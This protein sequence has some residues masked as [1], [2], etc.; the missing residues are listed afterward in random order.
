MVA[1]T[2]KRASAVPLWV[3]LAIVPGVVAL[4]I[5]S[6]QLSQPYALFGL[7]GSDDGVWL[8]PAIRL[9][10]GA[11]PYRDYA[12]VHPPGIALLLAPIG[13]L[14]DT[15]DALA[16]ARVV[17]ALVIGLDA[18]LAAIA[19]RYRGPVAMLVGG[20][21][22]AVFP[23]TASIGHS[24][25]IDPYLVLCCLLGMLAMFRGG[26]LAPPRRLLLAGAFFGLAAAMKAWGIFPAI[27]ALLVCLP[28]WRSAVRPFASGLVLGF[29]LPSLPFFMAA[30]SA[31]VHDVVFSQIIRS[32][33]G[34]GFT[35]VGDRLQLLLGF[36]P[37]T[38]ATMTYLALVIAGVLA[39][40]I[41]ATYAITA[42][43]SKRLDWFVLGATA[44]VAGVMLFVVK[45]IYTY[46]A[47]F[48]ASFG[49][50]LLGVCLGRIG[51]GIRWAGERI[52]GFA[53][54]AGG[55]AATA[56]MPAMIVIVAALLLPGHITY[57]ETFVSGAYD[58][59]AA[60][61]SQIPQGACVVF[62][63]AGILIDSNRLLP[64]QSGCPD[65]VDAF[66]LWLTDND[67]VPPPAQPQ[68]EAF[69]AKWLSWFERA[70]YVVLSVPQSDY[71]PWTPSL[72]SWFSANY[73]LVASQP[74]VYVYK[75]TA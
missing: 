42:R 46:Y 60:V 40:L 61:L 71:L 23:Q 56:G 62:D 50:L 5:C 35:S 45:E 75:H 10:H 29:G 52:G 37:S 67:G 16:V 38:D 24:V 4:G 33:T 6:Y 48:V 39:I 1:R 57:A 25:A 31:F 21:G 44:I 41:V 64:S 49:V 17:T 26:D 30:P 69:V 72:I 47:Y 66:G 8:A 70:D 74:N 7:H 11:L 36:T 54:R 65:L 14:G 28:L 58:P 9:V 13:L 27:G 18:S 73:H 19:L 34:Q 22:I 55:L 32:T 15:R 53:K 59:E 3:L 51:D 12:W 2:L 68:S 63:E 20:L 43:N